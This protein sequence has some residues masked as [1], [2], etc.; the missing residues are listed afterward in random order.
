MKNPLRKAAHAISALLYAYPSIHSKLKRCFLALPPAMRGRQMIWD[1]LVRLRKSQRR[2]SVL[3]IGA[4]DGEQADPVARF[5]RKYKWQ[6]VLVEPVPSIFEQLKRNYAGCPG[7]SFVNA[8]ISDQDEVR[9]FYYLDDPNDELPA[10]AHGLGSF[11]EHEVVNNEV[12]GR[13]VKNYLR[14]INVPCLSVA[15][16]LRQHDVQRVDVLVIDAQGFDGHIVRQIPFDRLRPK[17]LVYEHILLKPE[18]RRACDDLL[19]S[20]GYTLES[21]QWDVLATLNGDQ[22]HGGKK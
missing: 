13:T 3:Q 2:V 9:P 21:D 16:L 14:K 12:P 8:A 11:M 5:I 6:A 17:L 4:N 10:W 7:L 1:S 15:S 20:H 18:E 22:P 19:R